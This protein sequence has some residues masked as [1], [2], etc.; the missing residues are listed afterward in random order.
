[1]KKFL[2][3]MFACTLA[4]TAC[5]AVVGCGGGGESGDA[6]P[7]EAGDS[8]EPDSATGAGEEGLEKA[9]EGE[10]DSA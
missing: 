7:P 8:A 10:S 4:F 2:A 3:A 1:M 5:F 6:A 9:G